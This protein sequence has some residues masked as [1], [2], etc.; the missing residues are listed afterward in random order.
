M[1]ET[2]I[3]SWSVIVSLAAFLMNGV[4]PVPYEKRAESRYSLSLGGT[5]ANLVWVSP[6]P[7]ENLLELLL[8]IWW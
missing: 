2:F 8:G 4:L 7:A 5:L 3:S 6:A 1:S